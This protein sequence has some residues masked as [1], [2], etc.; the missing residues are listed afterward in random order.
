[1]RPLPRVVVNFLCQLGW[2]AWG[3][4]A[5][6]LEVILGVSVQMFLDEMDIWI[7]GLS[8]AAHPPQCGVVPSSPWKAGNRT[9]RWGGG[10]SGP[11]HPVLHLEHPRT[12]DPVIRCPA[13]TSSSGLRTYSP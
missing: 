6:C 2:A 7:S 1:M 4:I 9:Q 10:D 12:L 3:Q 5:V 8:S 13:S 11:W